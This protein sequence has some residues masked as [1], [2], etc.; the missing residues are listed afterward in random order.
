MDSTSNDSSSSGDETAPKRQRNEQELYSARS[1]EETTHQDDSTTARKKQRHVTPEQAT[2]AR[3]AAA[4]RM[5]QLRASASPEQAAAARQQNAL[6]MRHRRSVETETQQEQLTQG[7]ESCLQVTNASNTLTLS[8]Q[9]KHE[10]ISQDEMHCNVAENLT[11]VMGQM[12]EIVDHAESINAVGLVT[13]QLLSQ[14]TDEED[15]EDTVNVGNDTVTETLVVET[16]PQPAEFPHQSLEQEENINENGAE[17]ADT[18][19]ADMEEHVFAVNNAQVVP[20]Q[21]AVNVQRRRAFRSF[22]L[23]CNFDT[24]MEQV[25]SITQDYLG[26]MN[27]ACQYCNAL[28][29]KDENRGTAGSIHFGNMCC[30]KGNT[31]VPQLQP[32]PANLM[33]LYTSQDSTSKFFRKNIRKFNSGLSMASTR[34]D[35]DATVT[36]HQG[37]L[38]SF[39]IRGQ[40]YRCIG[41]L[42]PMENAQPR[43]IQTYFYDQDEQANIRADYFA[44]DENGGADRELYLMLFDQLQQ[45]LTE[46][47][48]TYLMSFLSVRE[49]I[50]R[51][52]VPPEELRIAIHAD[53]R[54]MDEHIRRYNLP[55][56]SEISILMPNDIQ[57]EDTRQVVCT[58]R[59]SAG[60]NNIKT[61]GDTHRSYDPLAYPLFLP[62]GTDGWT[63]VNY[64][65]V[66]LNQWLTYYMMQR[67]TFNV[68]H[69]GGKLYQQWLVDQYCKM[70]TARMRWVKNNQKTLRADLY[71]GVEDALQSGDLSNTGRHLILPSS[72]TASPRYYHKKCQDALTVCSKFGKP[73]L[74]ITMTTN[75]R[76]PEIV[77]QL[78]NGQT[79]HDRPDIVCRVFNEKK[80]LLIEVIEKECFFKV[81]ARVYSIE[82]QKRGLPHV[83]LLIF[84]AKP[85]GTVVTPTLVNDMI[86]AELPP[87]DTPLRSIVETCMIHGPC[88]VL[89]PRCA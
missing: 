7:T 67:N 1:F 14:E 39:K 49:V 48:N 43:C 20:A 37:G 44:S 70:E 61:L 29:Y 40:L 57:P 75:P 13:N 31:V 66:T 68:Y 21:P 8:T 52:N 84:L 36:N 47:Q 12:H 34:F 17:I 58:Y 10:N 72:I 2:A 51:M 4:L 86:S 60:V 27:F 24:S 54:P 45:I 41:P 23:K 82:F 11:H 46:C 19:E 71:R 85:E 69:H 88:G 53:I 62:Y 42:Q 76:W 25:L 9:D 26:P 5:Q 15:V 74:F 28:G 63:H 89:N 6:R 33:Q 80:K 16:N 50:Q 81:K 35:T 30:H 22:G 73:D 64:P 87:E 38:S 56:C 32:P 78:K 18:N 65:N 59:H 55:E 83:H 79:V 77:E 3:Q